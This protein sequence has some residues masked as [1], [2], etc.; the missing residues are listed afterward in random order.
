MRG[1]RTANALGNTTGQT[2]TQTDSER[3]AELE[4]IVTELQAVIGDYH[5]RADM[6]KRPVELPNGE[7]P[8]MF[9]QRQLGLGT[10]ELAARVAA[11]EARPATGSANA[12]ASVV[13]VRAPAGAVAIRETMPLV[14]R[15]YNEGDFELAAEVHDTPQQFNAPIGLGGPPLQ[16]IPVTVRKNGQIVFAIKVA[17][18]D[19]QE[20]T[21]D[22]MRLGAVLFE[23]HDNGVRLVQGGAWIGGQ[24]NRVQNEVR[25][26]AM[27][28]QG[29]VS[30]SVADFSQ[31]R[32]E[33]GQL[34]IIREDFENKHICITPCRAG[35]GVKVEGSTQTMNDHNPNPLD[36]SVTLVEPI[37]QTRDVRAEDYAG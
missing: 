3:I 36:R 32:G 19:T 6:A 24:L 1:M 13:P 17:S 34:W 26:L 7:Y 23:P 35:W 28:S 31:P 25:I 37:T 8:L 30:K 15:V 9:R 10:D 22:R 2:M 21:G 20:K 29:T 33:R 11:L 14:S 12:S 18:A 16:G 5:E 4:R 27:D